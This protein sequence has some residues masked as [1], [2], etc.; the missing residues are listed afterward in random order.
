MFI[1]SEKFDEI[2]TAVEHCVKQQYASIDELLKSS[3]EDFKRQEELKNR[4]NGNL[5]SFIP[6]IISLSVA[7]F[8]F[9]IEIPE[10]YLMK[11]CIIYLISIVALAFFICMSFVN[12]ASG[13]T[14]TYQY[15]DSVGTML[16]SISDLEKKTPPLTVY[17]I[18]YENT[19]SK[20]AGNIRVANMYFNK[21]KEKQIAVNQVKKWVQYSAISA[22]A[23]LSLLVI[24]KVDARIDSLNHPKESEKVLQ[25]LSQ[26]VSITNSYQVYETD[27]KKNV[28]KESSNEAKKSSQKVVAKKSSSARCKKD[29]VVIINV[30]SSLQSNQESANP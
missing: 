13:L 12:L 23:C 2:R 11:G 5:Y 21:N 26:P 30:P 3:E 15:K 17:E 4:T 6:H 8:T 27:N 25:C 18:K 29:T 7:L 10:F 20:I 16:D 28:I 19:I 14:K 22:L 24:F 1:D 9:A